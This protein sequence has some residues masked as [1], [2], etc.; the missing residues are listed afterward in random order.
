LQRLF[1]FARE[2]FSGHV[3]NFKY[4]LDIEYHYSANLLVDCTQ[5]PET[6]NQDELEFSFIQDVLLA[7]LSDLWHLYGILKP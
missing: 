3:C 6:N 5:H 4:Q 2:E 7:Q 1:A